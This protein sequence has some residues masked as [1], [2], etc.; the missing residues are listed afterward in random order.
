L[1]LEDHLYKKFKHGKPYN[2]KSRSLLFNLLDKKNPNARLALLTERVSPE[3]FLCMDIRKLA[4]DE[5]KE[6]R[7]TAIQ[8]NMH[9]KRTDWATE[10]VK[11]QGE[12]Y[13]GLF[14][15]ESCGSDKTGFI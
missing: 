13:K 11:Q 10:E 2:D 12:K 4:S 8:M 14:P 6:Q 9:D 1:R 7:Q 5:I 15:C 3:E